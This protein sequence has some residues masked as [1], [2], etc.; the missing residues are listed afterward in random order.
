MGNEKTI[1]KGKLINNEDR[2]KR[3][4]AALN[5]E[6]SSEM[7]F[8]Y[9][10]KECRD[11][12]K[13]SAEEKIEDFSLFDFLC[14]TTEDMPDMD[15][16]VLK[17]RIKGGE[18][19]ENKQLK[20]L[21]R[22]GELKWV[23]FAGMKNEDT[24]L[25][26]LGKF[27]D[28]TPLAE[29]I[30]IYQ[31]N[32]KKYES[33]LDT[34]NDIIFTID[35]TGE[36]KYISEN[37]IKSLEYTPEELKGKNALEI[38][39]P[40]DAAI[41]KKMLEIFMAAPD[42]F[43]QKILSHR[44]ISKSGG[45]QWNETRGS[46]LKNDQGENTGILGI[47]RNVTEIKGAERKIL[48]NDALLR[49][50]LEASLDAI[51]IF[52][53]CYNEEG[54]IIDF[55]AKIVNKQAT[56][57]M[58]NT[59]KNLA[60]SSISE[61][62]PINIEN[63]FLE[64]YKR[65]AKTGRPLMEEYFIPEDF[66]GQGWFQHQ[67]VQI[68][69]GIAINNKEI[70]TQK[71]IQN[72]LIKSEIEAISLARQYKN[73]LNSQSIYVVKIN[74]D[75]YYTYSN[76]YFEK[77]F[78]LEGGI[79]GTHG[80]SRIIEEDRP[81]YTSTI[82]LC[83]QKIG[84]S[85]PVILKKRNKFGEIKSG[86]WE[87][88][89]TPGEDGLITEVLCVGFD[90]TEQIENLEKAQHLLEVTSE[91]NTRLKSFTYIV[92]HNIRSHV[93][94][95]MGLLDV[96]KSTQAEEERV[97]FLEMLETSTNRL[98]ET[99]KNLNEIIS[100]QESTTKSKIEKNL[101]KEVIKNLEILSGVIVKENIQI[102]LELSDNITINVIPSYLDSILLNLISNAIKYRDPNKNPEI[103]ITA[104]EL[105]GQLEVRI[106]DNGLGIDLDR[107]GKKIFG[108]Y[109]T[110]HNNADARGFGLYITKTQIEAMG[111]KISVESTPGTGSTFT[112]IFKN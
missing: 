76:D 17:K 108:M 111:G 29:K 87:F 10:N 49:S 27:I 92:S 93:A 48:D 97:L 41:V 82:E 64:K 67:V 51:Y 102:G 81:K 80:M 88:K 63:G 96:V 35:T 104:K 36:F 20:V 25:T 32:E 8:I 68:P 109:K 95:M 2:F 69:N 31:S 78:G 13:I 101:K 12:L 62:F 72:E 24:P 4:N 14:T 19:I 100:I 1:Y 99:L 33:L 7:Y 75:G 6:V 79:I 110:F 53:N 61:F 47:A 5:W 59:K 73:I 34:A 85:I 37:V 54:E 70:T 77:L 60:D 22:S 46:V 112:I 83:F 91:Q 15:I 89:V 105:P 40:E 107:Y 28:V 26:Y 38:I 21:T 56:L 11:F 39:H 55:T 18:N 66:P 98:D 43:S 103:I 42:N 90:I 52:E 9:M 45:I 16:A 65:V 94:N 106:T 86:K 57:Q 3:L 23:T 71:N 84:Q 74:L 50:T 58:N 44:V 30:L